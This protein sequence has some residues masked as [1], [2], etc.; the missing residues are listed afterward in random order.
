MVNLEVT[1]ECMKLSCKIYDL[2]SLSKF[3]TCY[4]NPGKPSTLICHKRF[5][6]S[7]AVETDLSD[8][9]KVTATVMKTS[10]H[11]HKARVT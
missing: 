7:P 11:N 2:N 8:F 10:F 6:S 4:E 1:L 5:P 9:H 3:S